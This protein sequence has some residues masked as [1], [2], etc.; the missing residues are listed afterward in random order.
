MKLGPSRRRERCALC[1]SVRLTEVLNL[2]HTP[3]ANEF[4]AEEEAANQQEVF[5]LVLVMC[6]SCKH[7]QIR[8]I[9]SSKRLFD[10]YLY[11]TGTSPVTIE[12]FKNQAATLAENLKL[13]KDGFIVEIGSNDGTLLAEFKKLGYRNI[14][15]VDPARSIAQ[16][17]VDR[18]VNTLKEFFT[19]TLA[20]H[21]VK[22]RENANLVIANNVFAH[23]EDIRDIA[24]GARE[25]IGRNGWFVFEVSYLM[26]IAEY[27]TFDTIY[28]EHFS[29][30]ALVPLVAMFDE[31]GMKLY[32]AERVPGQVGRGSLRCY[33]APRSRKLVS[34]LRLDKLIEEE[35]KAGILWS[36]FYVNTKMQIAAAGGVLSG[37]LDERLAQGDT[38]VGYGAPA[39]LT[40]LMYSFGLGTKHAKFIVDDSEWKQGLFT[41]G[42]HIPVVP[43]TALINLPPKSVVVVYA[44]NFADDII[45]RFANLDVVWV[46]PAPKFRRVVVVEHGMET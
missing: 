12:H 8:D 10:N 20:E 15:G 1:Q 22:A 33:A 21:I 41:P 27:L 6:Q 16:T 35:K 3:L 17:A 31:L 29:Y 37:F 45:K 14:L 36:D 13:S 44:W 30:H 40:T 39:K 43:P 42:L 46:V 32:D 24:I 9:V 18:G 2:G 11:A 25:L 7:V 28:H 34:N 38:V 23:A 26:D 19:S 4:V 5:P